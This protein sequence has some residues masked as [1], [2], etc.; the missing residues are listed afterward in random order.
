[1]TPIT[2][3]ALKEAVEAEWQNGNLTESA[4][5]RILAALPPSDSGLRL[6]IEPDGS[7][8]E[9]AGGGLEHPIRTA[10]SEPFYD[11]IEAWREGYRVGFSRGG[12]LSS[13]AEREIVAL[14]R[15]NADA[16]RR[17]SKVP[18]PWDEYDLT[19]IAAAHCREQAR[20]IAAAYDA[21]KGERE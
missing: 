14:G 18:H 6:T 13:E 2:Q 19:E 11:Q 15:L 9:I 1:M 12:G 5:D 21:D 16:I 17:H 7:I 4:M 8:S 10:G 3:E 20:A